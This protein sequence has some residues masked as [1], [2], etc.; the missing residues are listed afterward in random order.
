MGYI[1]Q[2]VSWVLLARAKVSILEVL[3]SWTSLIIGGAADHTWKLEYHTS[4]TRQCIHRTRHVHGCNIKPILL[5]EVWRL[6]VA[7]RYRYF[8]YLPPSF[9]SGS[10]SS[11]SSRSSLFGRPEKRDLSVH[12]RLLMSLDMT[13]TVDSGPSSNTEI[14]LSNFHE[15]RTRTNYVLLWAEHNWRPRVFPI[16]VSANIVLFTQL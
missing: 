6:L 10:C 2:F 1:M 4:Y 5:F 14:Q 9:I 13:N 11:T 8:L 3:G 7:C 15:V 16:Q 12:L